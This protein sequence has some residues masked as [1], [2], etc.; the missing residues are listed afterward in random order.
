MSKGPGLWQRAILA[1][2]A[3]RPAFYLREMLPWRCTNGQYNALLRAALRLEEDGK[4]QIARFLWGASPGHAKTVVHRI[5]TEFHGEDRRTLPEL[6][7][8]K[9]W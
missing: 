2:L 8:D 6:P 3:G 7:R 4:I 1:Q 5:G 9:W